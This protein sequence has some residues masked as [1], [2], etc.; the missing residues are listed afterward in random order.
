[1][2]K[3]L[4]L[5]MVLGLLLVLT[6]LANAEWVKG[7]HSLYVEEDG[8]EVKALDWYW[9]SPVLSLSNGNVLMKIV[10]QWTDA[11]RKNMG[12]SPSLSSKIK[13]TEYIVEL[14]FSNNQF[15][16]R[17]STIIAF[18]G[19]SY[20]ALTDKKLY[21][22]GT[23]EWIDLAKPKGWIPGALLPEI[24]EVAKSAPKSEGR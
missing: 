14:N 16:Y 5:A 1:M 10:C 3:L 22:N 21:P 7:P 13:R 8:Q 6:P 2:K 9:V 23:T 17:S 18:D 15:R 11:G 4:M 24:F 20:D 12:Y 19:E